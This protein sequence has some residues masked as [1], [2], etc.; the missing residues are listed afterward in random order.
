MRCNGTLILPPLL[1]GIRWWSSICSA[2]ID[3]SHNAQMTGSASTSC[4]AKSSL[5][6]RAIELLSFYRVSAGVRAIFDRPSPS[7]RQ[8]RARCNEVGIFRSGN[9]YVLSRTENM[10]RRHPNC[11]HSYQAVF[12]STSG[13]DNLG[14]SRSDRRASGVLSQIFDCVISGLISGHSYAASSAKTSNGERLSFANC[15]SR[16]I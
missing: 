4:E 6:L 11:G 8:H 14:R 5:F 13:H 15:F 7:N 16:I 1:L 2:G 10:G 12:S 9:A 3:R